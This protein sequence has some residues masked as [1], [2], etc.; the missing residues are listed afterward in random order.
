MNMDQ[1]PTQEKPLF[2]LIIDL[3][4]KP[5]V[6]FLSGKL[7]EYKK[8]VEPNSG[9]SAGTKTDAS[10]KIVIM[11]ELLQTGEVDP[12][13]ILDKVKT[14]V[15]SFARADFTNAYRVVQ[16]YII[17]GGKSLAN[18]GKTFSRPEEKK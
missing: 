16:G 2:T 10:L 11:E 18:V 17:D 8:R 12:T 15:G 3:K 6:D 1:Q 7:A 14:K 9:R 13:A 5:L 4:D